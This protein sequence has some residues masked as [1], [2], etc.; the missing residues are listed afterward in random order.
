MKAFSKDSGHN[1]QDPGWKL[2]TDSIRSQERFEDLKS[3]KP[4]TRS[5]KGIFLTTYDAVDTSLLMRRLLPEWLSLKTNFDSSEPGALYVNE[6][7]GRLGNIPHKV[8]VSTSPSCIGNYPWLHTRHF[9][10][11]STAKS[12]LT[13]HSKLW[14][15]WVEE[16]EREF[17]EICVSSANLTNDSFANQIQIA[18]RCKISIQAKSSK[19]NRASWGCLDQF[20]KS[21]GEDCSGSQEIKPFRDLLAKAKCPGKIKFIAS[22]PRRTNRPVMDLPNQCTSITIAT[23]TIGNWTSETL[24]VWQNRIRSLSG[25]INLVCRQEGESNLGYSFPA[26][27]LESQCFNLKRTLGKFHNDHRHDDDTR[28]LHGKLYFFKHGRSISTL[29]TSANMTTSAWGTDKTPPK[30]YELGVLIAGTEPITYN[31]SLRDFASNGKPLVVE[32]QMTNSPSSEWGEALW[33]GSAIQVTVRSITKPGGVVTQL[34]GKDG[35]LD[36]APSTP[37]WANEGKFWSA[38]YPWASTDGTPIMLMITGKSLR[39]PIWDGRSDENKEKYPPQF[40]MTA[41]QLQKAH[42]EILL[43]RYGKYSIELEDEDF[44]TLTDGSEGPAPPPAD[45]SVRAFVE[46]RQYFKIIENWQVACADIPVDRRKA[47]LRDGQ[48]LLDYFKAK[49]CKEIPAKLVAAE[50]TERIELL[51]DLWKK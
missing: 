39:I 46:A 28:W 33:D 21:L 31:K 47:M 12:E 34:W 3:F 23:P 6:I 44:H 37:I 27:T 50:L 42:Y 48:E 40:G 11:L 51:R 5:I 22:I 20:L 10:I 30:N 32:P 18:W 43:R 35:N 26:S 36:D 24:A 17:I 2:L 14:M 45:Y 19:E 4:S 9:R 8:I 1:P 7:D 13:Q 29:V 25:K 49:S 38:T 41:E 16:D 15:L